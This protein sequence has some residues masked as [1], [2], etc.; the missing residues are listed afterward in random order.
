MLC[1]F[2]VLCGGFGTTLKQMSVRV[3][4]SQL[5]TKIHN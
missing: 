4:T 5:W 2:K 1:Y 3:V